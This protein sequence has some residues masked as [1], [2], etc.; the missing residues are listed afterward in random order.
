M[1][2][3]SSAFKEKVKSSSRN[4]I[5][6]AVITLASQ[7]ELT[8]VNANILFD[9]FEVED[10]V[11]SDNT[12]DALGSTIINKCTIILY[13][14]DESYSAYDFDDAHVVVSTG[15][16]ID[17]TTEPI[18]LGVYTV[19]EANYTTNSIV[20]S[21]LDNMSKFDR[22]YSESQLAYPATLSQIVSDAC[23]VCGVTFNFAESDFVYDTFSVATKPDGNSCTFRDV[24]GWVA[25][26]NGTFARFNSFGQL[27]FK[28]FDLSGRPIPTDNITVID[29]NNVEHE[30][31]SLVLSDGTVVD[32]ISYI[33]GKNTSLPEVSSLFSQDIAVSDITIT[34]ITITVANIEDEA[35][36]TSSIGTDDYRITISDNPFIT[37]DNIETVIEQI[38]DKV[39]D[40]SFRKCS[41]TCVSNPLLEAGDT[42]YLID[43]KGNEHRILL[44]RVTFSP[45]ANQTIVCGADT[46]SRKSATLYNADTRTSAQLKSHLR[47][48]RERLVET[49]TIAGNTNQY[50]WF[51]E[52]G[53]DT[54]A[55]IT[56]VPQ[57]EFIDPTSEN[58][59]AGY[60]ALFR[61]IG[62][63]IRNGLTELATFSAN[64][65]RLGLG[66]AKH[67]LIDPDGISLYSAANTLLSNFTASDVRLYVAGVLRTL[68]SSSGLTV[69]D[70]TGEK[71]VARFGED[72]QIG[73]DESNHLGIDTTGIQGVNEEGV[74][75]FSV[76][77]DGGIITTTRRMDMRITLEVWNE[78]SEV[79][80]DLFESLQPIT[81]PKGTVITFDR[82]GGT[83]GYLSQALSYDE[84]KFL[85][86]QSLIFEPITWGTDSS[87]TITSRV[88][89]QHTLEHVDGKIF[90]SSSLGTATAEYNERYI[91]EITKPFVTTYTPGPAYTFGTRNNE[92]SGAFSTACGESLSAETRDQFA[93]GRYNED[94]SDYAMM[95]GN[96]SEDGD[97][98]AF[99]VTWDGSA[100]LGF[101]ADATSGTDASIYSLLRAQDL[102]SYMIQNGML[103]LKRLI[104]HVLFY[105]VPHTLYNTKLSAPSTQNEYAYAGVALNDWNVVLMR[106][107]C[108]NTRQLLVFCRLFG[109]NP[110]Y[111]SDMSGSTY[112]RGGYL[113]NW[114]SNQIGVRW[115]NG[116]AS[117]AGNIYVQQVYGI[118]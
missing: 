2:T 25:T 5:N 91:A 55:H 98:N 45:T 38:A 51:T 62:F 43:T 65:I 29:E 111:L 90:F 117:I 81:F 17:G 13:N 109:D 96:G 118:M 79:R 4:F 68:L 76:D 102:D 39:L 97:S 110:M 74:N 72:S 19:E 9:G 101:D 107:E 87:Q 93:C 67:I 3:A 15:L 88:G 71:S 23:T 35:D 36:I 64:S 84:T 63:A 47:S 53:T 59:H 86:I 27:E 28:W 16:E 66:N 18:Q 11:G 78:Q 83:Y 77:M 20:L 104:A 113:V 8:I 95:V 30:H 69:Y 106:C 7:E 26:I 21:M 57:E 49:E 108:H 52:E 56:E 34:G 33:P 92:T 103:D 80:K 85:S 42:A 31:A 14:G 1:R 41:I 114:S 32:T 12:F 94:N 112:V 82:S 24:I 116:T 75:V 54:G 10:S 58:Y 115:V 40:L 44:T 105:L 37:A 99:A 50:F 70:E 89:T 46:P 48:L 61:S 22:P 73:A 60:N 100:R 6:T